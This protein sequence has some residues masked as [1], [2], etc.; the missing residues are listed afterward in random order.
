MSN[1]LRSRTIR[2]AASLPQGE[3][4]TALLD[5][6]AATMTPGKY[7]TIKPGGG[8]FDTRGMWFLAQE[9][10]KNGSMRGLLVMWYADRR[11]PEKAKIT[12]VD[13]RWAN[14][15]WLPIE[16]SEIEPKALERFR[17]RA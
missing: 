10:Q 2:L 17:A 3:V 4:R 14:D 6:L 16:E 9:V 1:T 12:Q 15:S 5:V 8:G 13:R 11:V 7:Y